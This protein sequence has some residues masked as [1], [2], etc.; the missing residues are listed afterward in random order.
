MPFCAFPRHEGPWALEGHARS[1]E[2]RDRWAG[3]VHPSWF[4]VHAPPCAPSLQLAM[5]PSMHGVPLM[6]PSVL[7]APRT[8]PWGAVPG[9][10]LQPRMQS[11]Q[12]PVLFQPPMY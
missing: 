4:I 12:M 10:M 11:V 1:G 9:C 6:A 8:M 2:K 7:S 3:H 5:G